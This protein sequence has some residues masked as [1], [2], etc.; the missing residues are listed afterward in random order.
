MA[1]SA[2]DESPFARVRRVGPAAP[3]H[4]VALG[5]RDFRAAPLASGFYGLAFAVMG[6]LIAWVFRHAY[7]YVWGLS[8]GFL[9]VG[10]ILAI[11]LYDLSRQR[12]EGRRPRLAPS[13][14][15]WRARTGS[16]GLFTLVLGVLMLL[17]S[18]ASLVVIALFFP[19]E[20]PS[21]AS[22]TSNALS[23]DHLEFLVA[24]FA[25]GGF[26]ATLAF[27]I[28]AVSIPMMLD[29]DTDGIAAALTSIRACLDNPMPMLVWGGLVALLIGGGIATM[30][31]G[32]VVTGPVMGHAAWHAYRALVE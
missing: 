27:A 14:V 25:V 21:F 9:L 18:R 11:G 28:A 17:W 20:M 4:W 26:F 3:L 31:V 30:F 15:A 19:N 1:E 7:A 6:A 10:P 22:F 32:L 2:G 23:T 16:I 13:L 24:Y 8:T 29:R 5:W 12:M